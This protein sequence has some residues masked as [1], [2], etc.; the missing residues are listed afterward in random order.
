MEGTEGLATSFEEDRTSKELPMTRLEE[1]ELVMALRAIIASLLP[2]E[3]I[4]RGK[5]D[6]TTSVVFAFNSSVK[7][8][9]EIK[10]NISPGI[11][12]RDKHH[13]YPCVIGNRD[14]NHAI[15]RV[16]VLVL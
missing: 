6:K 1:R 8:D 4:S 5:N 16:V 9:C 11:R 3:S 12:I 7:T 13:V 10:G 14:N 2:F 15:N